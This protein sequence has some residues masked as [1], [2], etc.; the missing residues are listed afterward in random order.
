MTGK[1]FI[2]ATPIGNLKDITLRAISA[3]KEADIIFAED[4]RVVKKLLS[5]LNISKP[6][7]RFD[8]NI[9]E[10]RIKKLVEN[11]RDGKNVALVSDAG[12]PNLS[13]PGWRL[14]SLVVESGISVVPIPGASALA[15]IISICHFPLREFVFLG[16]PP[17]KKG[18]E[19]FF[20]GISEEIR[21]VILYESTHRILKT[22][23]SL[24]ETTPEREIVVAK[25]LTKIYEHVWRGNAREVYETLKELSSDE[26]KGEWAIIL[27][28]NNS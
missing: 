22:T 15:A 5:H 8:D 2:V 20:K 17:T 18:R 9:S 16:F 21:P 1:L 25:E 19:K 6:T 27:G 11:L 4:T 3:L 23:E 28:S 26:L 13:D 24:S 10:A 14:V 7:E 12:T